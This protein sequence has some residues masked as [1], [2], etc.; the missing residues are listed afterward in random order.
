M[1]AHRSTMRYSLL[2]MHKATEAPGFSGLSL[3]DQIIAV[4]MIMPAV[5]TA[6]GR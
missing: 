2:R 1:L 5:T 4:M 6:K 3:M